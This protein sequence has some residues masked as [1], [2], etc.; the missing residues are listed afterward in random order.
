MYAT[1]EDEGEE[2]MRLA[3]DVNEYNNSVMEPRCSLAEVLRRFVSLQIDLGDFLQ[4]C[5]RL[6]AREYTI[7]SSNAAHPKR[8]H[9]TVSIVNDDL[10]SNRR[11]RG[12]CTSFLDLLV[13]PLRNSNGRRPK[14]L[15]GMRRVHPSAYV[16]VRPSTFRAPTN[17]SLPMIMIGPGTGIAPMRAL[18]QDRALLMDAGENVGPTILFFGCKR[19]DQDFVYRDELQDYRDNGVLSELHLAFSREQKHKVYVQHLIQQQGASMWELLQ[20]RGAYVYVCGGASM[21]RDVQRAFEDVAVKQGGLSPD[22]AHEYMATLSK[23]EHRYIE[24]LWS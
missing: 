13:P 18:L 3:N 14:G 20:D 5:P 23:Q 8:I 21:G 7:S 9:L 17:P 4:L 10:G 16:C 15:R 24:E 2:L 11:W 22:A 1:S 6:Q 19:Q 12:V